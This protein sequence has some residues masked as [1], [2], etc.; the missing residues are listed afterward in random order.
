MSNV[1]NIRLPSNIHSLWVIKKIISPSYLSR[2]Y[3]VNRIISKFLAWW[4]KQWKLIFYW[5]RIH[6]TMIWTTRSFTFAIMVFTYFPQLTKV[7]INVSGPI[8]WWVETGCLWTS[9]NGARVSQIWFS[10]TLGKLPRA[11]TWKTRSWAATA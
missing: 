4:C 5:S 11:Q 10:D 7:K 1:W 9:W 2:E 6:S 8:W 3:S